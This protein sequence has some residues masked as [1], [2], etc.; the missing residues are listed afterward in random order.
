[1]LST[2]RDHPKFAGEDHTAKTRHKYQAF[3]KHYVNLLQRNGLEYCLVDNQFFGP[4]MHPDEDEPLPLGEPTADMLRVAPEGS[5][6]A[7]ILRTDEYN[8]KIKSDTRDKF[9]HFYDR[10][11]KH[12]GNMS[13]AVAL[14]YDGLVPESPAMS[15]IQKIFDTESH[16]WLRM[17]QSM[18]LL[19]EKWMHS[20]STISER[21]ILD[22]IKLCTDERYSQ[23]NRTAQFTVLVQRLN[24]LDAK[25]TSERQLFDMYCDGVKNTFLR[26]FVA[27]WQIDEEKEK[28]WERLA[29]KLDK[30]IEYNPDQDTCKGRDNASDATA[31][32]KNSVNA[33][34]VITDLRATDCLICGFTGHRGK[35]CT[36]PKCKDC[37][38]E[39]TSKKSRSDHWGTKCPKRGE[40]GHKRKQPGD[41]RQQSK[42]SRGDSRQTGRKSIM[43]ALAALLKD[44]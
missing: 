9:K 8:A 42:R 31:Q 36:E 19:D 30:V 12:R 3:R 35:D 28:K 40:S 43:K 34:S 10:V 37:G 4:N 6:F 5:D 17:R 39:F 23:A 29:D 18:D 22:E 33:N 27:D 1:M 2:L 13:K 14:L 25:T 41:G 16:P 44:D 11:E 15:H 20:G 32:G 38:F 7:T 24:A 21:D 26:S